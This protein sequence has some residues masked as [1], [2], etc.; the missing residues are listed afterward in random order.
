MLIR[1]ILPVILCTPLLVALDLS[2]ARISV[3]PHATP[4]EQLAARV[5]QEEIAKRSQITLPLQGPAEMYAIVL[6]NRRSGPLEGFQILHSSHTLEVTGNDERGLLYGVGYLLRKLEMERGRIDLPNASIETSPKT[7]LRGHQLGYRPKTNSYDGWTIAQW[8]Q[9]I[10]ELALFGTNAIELIPPRSDDA[11]DSPHFPAPQMET[12]IAM[13]RIADQ[14]GLDVWVW[15]PAL[16]PDYAEQKWVDFALKEWETIFS[17][18]PRI[19]AIFVPGGDPGHTHP[20]HLFPMLE[21]QA[22]SLRRHH[23]KA[24]WWVAPQGFNSEWLGEFYSLV[25]A[26]PTWLRGIVHGPQLRMPIGELRK[27]IPARYPIRNYPDITHSLRC[28]FPVLD[29]DT[30]YALTLNREPINPRPV[31]MKRIFDESA[32]HTVGFITYSE[33]CNDDVNKFLW[34]ALGWDPA[35]DLHETLRDYSRLLIHPRLAAS[36]AEGLFALERNWRGPLATNANVIT[37]LQQFEAMDSIATPAVQQNWRFQQ[38]QYRAHY[39]AYTRAR[40]IYETS[41][42]QQA[43]DRLRQAS[44]L[45]ALHAL[46]QAE[47]VLDRAITQ[48]TAPGWRARTFELGEALFQSIRMQL[49]VP[50]YGAIAVGRGANLDL[51]D[52]PLNNRPWLAGHFAHIRTL[53]NEKERLAAIGEILD[54]SNPGPGGFYDDLGNP[55][56]SP[57]LVRAESPGPESR[58]G[59]L[60]GFGDPTSALAKTW[61]YSWMNQAEVLFDQPLEMRYTGLDPV[62]KY[63]LRILYA[64][65]RSPVTIK[66]VANG[67]FEVHPERTRPSPP[68]VLEFAI[69]A[70]VTRGGTLGLKWTRPA[71][72]GGNGR[73]IQIAEVWLVRQ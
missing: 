67:R 18:L 17:K 71:G 23:P 45:G 39:D 36:F 11:A 34:S 44:E 13:S 31:D 46:D 25:K 24:Q 22:A 2:H 55:S 48:R 49:S 53:T 56:A 19:D 42:E 38:A 14:Y 61:R 58:N 66:L 16:D 62:A 5:L 40:L 59:A 70:D 3:P 41:L 50:Y 9:Y 73:G 63:Q 29:W 32:P 30:A 26:N 8:E 15:Y 21:K 33:G 12:M 43:M 1:G 37:T 57:H 7:A 54:W 47:R 60:I 20:K 64:G 69:P 68:E 65:D 72:G 52:T 10:R 28:Q 51:I 4:R 35:A 6:R 27:Q